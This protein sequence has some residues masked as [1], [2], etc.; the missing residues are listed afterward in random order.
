[1]SVTLSAEEYFTLTMIQ[2][3][4]SYLESY[5]HWQQLPNGIDVPSNVVRTDPP[6]LNS[7]I[8]DDGG[9]SQGL[10]QP[11]DE[12][13]RDE[14]FDI[15]FARE[16]PMVAVRQN[17]YE[18]DSDDGDEPVHSEEGVAEHQLAFSDAEWHEIR[19]VYERLRRHEARPC[20][21]GHF[22]YNNHQTIRDSQEESP[23]PSGVAT[24]ILDPGEL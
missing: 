3:Q 2:I 10:Q 23:Q 9:G 6:Q 17:G 24:P 18:S 4:P 21:P 7:E 13:P 11:A 15:A 8:P 20:Y 14:D 16:G 1:M 19:A 5:Y 22:L 12:R